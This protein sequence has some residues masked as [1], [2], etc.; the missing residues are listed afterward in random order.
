MIH[1]T[2][3]KIYSDVKS[4]TVDV[5]YDGNTIQLVTR[6]VTIISIS[7][8]AGALS[9]SQRAPHTDAAAR[10]PALESNAVLDVCDNL[11]LTGKAAMG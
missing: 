7:G 10:P 9:D 5:E 11:K 1:R 6:L 4:T 8:R 3:C 2:N